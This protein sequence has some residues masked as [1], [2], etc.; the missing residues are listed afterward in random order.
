MTNGSGGFSVFLPP[1]LRGSGSRPGGNPGSQPGGTG[2]SHPS[3]L[4]AA[5]YW[6]AVV[7]GLILIL[8][9]P[10]II[11]LPAAALLIPFAIVAALLL[12]V[13]LG[14][15]ALLCNMQICNLLSLFSWIFNWSAWIL[16][17]IGVLTGNGLLLI[18]GV[19]YGWISG[20]I[21]RDMWARNC[22]YIP[23]PFRRP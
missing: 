4:C 23:G 12:A 7:N 10:L 8:S 15:L 1:W 16:L 18:I 20:L 19:L 3:W 2:S 14:M 17:I 5:F 21:V 13:S 6:L 22:S 9:I 11:A